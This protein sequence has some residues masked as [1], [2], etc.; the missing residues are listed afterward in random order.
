MTFELAAWHLSL[1]FIAG[2]LLGFFMAAVICIG[3]DRD[4]R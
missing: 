4:R 2:G 1:I 3:S